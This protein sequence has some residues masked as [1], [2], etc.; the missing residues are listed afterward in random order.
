LAGPSIPRW[1]DP[2]EASSFYGSKPSA[3]RRERTE[4]PIIGEEEEMIDVSAVTD[5]EIPGVLARP[6]GK[7]GK[8]RAREDVTVMRVDPKSVFRFVRE[9]SLDRNTNW[10]LSSHK[11]L[12][13]V[14]TDFLSYRF[15]TSRKRTRNLIDLARAWK[16]ALEDTHLQE[17]DEPV[18]IVEA[19][20]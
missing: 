9:W 11:Q 16:N 14:R 2:V 12:D 6:A 19:W 3:S 18:E 1:N 4:S 5:L 8:C 10:A 17:T 20:T 13:I 15:L 7:Y